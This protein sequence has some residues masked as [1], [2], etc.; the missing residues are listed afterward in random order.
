MPLS[1]SPFSKLLLNK[2]F[3]SNLMSTNDCAFVIS[4]EQKLKGLAVGNEGNSWVMRYTFE[5]I[6]CPGTL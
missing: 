1:S 6:C 4:Y 2:Y 5:H 3:G